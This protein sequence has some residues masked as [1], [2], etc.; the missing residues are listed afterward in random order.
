MHNINSKSLMSKILFQEKLSFK[1]Q[2][3]IRKDVSLHIV[4]IC[5]KMVLLKS[6]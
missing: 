1:P 3:L 5:E 4:K 6:E 2:P